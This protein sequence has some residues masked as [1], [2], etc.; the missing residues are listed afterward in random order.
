M[1]VRPSV[2]SQGYHLIDIWLI[3]LRRN[4]Q[5]G[6]GKS[7]AWAPSFLGT[8]GWFAGSPRPKAEGV[9]QGITYLTLHMH[10][11]SSHITLFPFFPFSIIGGPRRELRLVLR[12]IRLIGVC[13]PTCPCLGSFKTYILAHLVDFNLLAFCWLSKAQHLPL[14]TCPLTS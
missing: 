9:M 11:L 7:L 1:E 13:F 12:N 2:R 8:D 4:T 10:G 14:K 3:P 6:G 5:F